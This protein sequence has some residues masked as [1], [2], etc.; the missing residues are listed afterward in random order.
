MYLP[1]DGLTSL[2]QK[3]MRYQGA[4]PFRDKYVLTCLGHISAKDC[5]SPL[6]VTN[7]NAAEKEAKALPAPNDD[8]PRQLAFRLLQVVVRTMDIVETEKVI[9][10]IEEEC[11][12][13]LQMLI[14]ELC[15]FEKRASMTLGSFDDGVLD[16]L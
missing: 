8:L 16:L 10:Q 12:D 5:R 3:I 7:D 9:D 14:D 15:Q 11:D 4:E 2:F 6:E 13:F 1:P